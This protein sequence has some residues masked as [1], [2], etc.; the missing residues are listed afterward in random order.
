[1][2]KQGGGRGGEG[3]GGNILH[4]GTQQGGARRT[5]SNF[6]H[7]EISG[8]R[9]KGGNEFAPSPKRERKGRRAGGVRKKERSA[10]SKRRRF[11]IRR[12]GALSPTARTDGD[13]A[14]LRSSVRQRGH[15]HESLTLTPKRVASRVAQDRGDPAC[16]HGEKAL[17]LLLPPPGDFGHRGSCLCLPKSRGGHPRK[18]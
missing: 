13:P 12:R 8:V 14:L 5:E 9:S 2:P 4:A 17:L 6:F 16:R 11:L 15:C 10:K 3:A 7:D 1:M 18:G